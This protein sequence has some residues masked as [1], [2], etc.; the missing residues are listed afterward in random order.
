MKTYTVTDFRRNIRSVMPTVLYEK[1]RVILT[2]YNMQCA[3]IPID[4]L[5]KLEA[6][7]RA[8]D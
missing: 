6:Y 3:I 2:S 1:E 7:E 5:R 4:D 8:A